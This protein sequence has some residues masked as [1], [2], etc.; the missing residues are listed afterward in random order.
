MAGIGFTLKRVIGG[1]E[2]TGTVKGYVA[3]AVVAAGPWL[4]SV[5][6]M[7]TLGVI[8]AFGLDA[9]QRNILFGS[10][11]YT[12]AF[13]LICV[14]PV[15]LVFTRYIA[16]AEYL[17]NLERVG[18]AFA[19]V[20]IATATVALL[21]AALFVSQLPA[22]SPLFRAAMLALFVGSL[23]TWL[24]LAAVS[25]A[26]DYVLI[27]VAFGFGYAIGLIGALLA[28][29][30]T[31]ID[32]YLVAFTLGQLTVFGVLTAGTMRHFEPEPSWHFEILGYL[33]KY[34]ALVLIGLSYNAGIWVDKL[35]M[36]FG[37]AG[38]S[39]IGNLHAAPTYD[40]AMFI[41]ALSMVPGLTVFVLHVETDFYVPYRR[42]FDGIIRKAPLR[43]LTDARHSMAHA[44]RHGF[45]VLIEVQVATVLVGLL[46]ER[47]LMDLVGLGVGDSGLYRVGLLANSAQVTLLVSLL[48]LLYFDQ[49]RQAAIVAV[50]FVL[51]NVGLTWL[52]L[53]LGPAWHGCGYLGAALL[54]LS[55]AQLLLW[56]HLER[57]E[58]RTF[59]HEAALADERAIRVAA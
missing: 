5:A 34:P 20:T 9:E 42:F 36:W 16:D 13:S 33:G 4:L 23:G 35:V 26:R 51:C 27:M 28:G 21:P 1:N 47:A 30:R 46:F 37:P 19:V 2:P 50:T 17:R 48:G 45:E 14:G 39:I 18:A 41:S 56:R 11:L 12:Y 38:T 58:Y 40:R 6:T 3:A 59:T 22:L 54:G 57:L 7:A 55:L 43:E 10:I 29:P 8:S 32:G 44:L 15:Q 53:L 25:A 52:S 49:R 31:G 24:A